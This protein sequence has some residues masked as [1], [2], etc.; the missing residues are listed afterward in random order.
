M[1]TVLLD[2]PA[3]EADAEAEVTLAA[4]VPE[5]LVELITVPPTLFRPSTDA[6]LITQRGSWRPL[7]ASTISLPGLRILATRLGSA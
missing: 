1:T 4:G 5:A 2:A 6:E 3:I 7:M